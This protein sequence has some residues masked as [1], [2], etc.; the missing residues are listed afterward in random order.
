MNPTNWWRSMNLRQKIFLAIVIAANLALWL[1]T[2]D[3]ERLVARDR[4]ILLGRYS[5]THFTWIMAVALLSVVGL[6]IDQA[7]TLATYKKR[8]F[9]V[10]AVVLFL[11]PGLALLDFAIR[12]TRP[13]AY[14]HD[15]L[16]YHRPPNTT[17]DY[18]FVDR[19]ETGLVLALAPDGHPP[20]DCR[21]TADA[22]GFRN[23]DVQPPFDVIALGDSF[24]EGCNVSDDQA[25]PVR[26]A[27]QAD[28]S[29][30]NLG[31]TG[32]TPRHYLA[33]L[34]QHGDEV[35][36]AAVICLL[37]EG[38]DFE[39]D[40]EDLAPPDLGDR[41]EEYFETSPLRTGME[42]LM[43][44]FFSTAATA[45]DPRH[46]ELFSWLPLQIPDSPAGHPYAFGPKALR[47]HSQSADDFASSGAWRRTAEQIAALQAY[48]Q[49]R[50]IEL[51]LAF[52]PTKAHVVLPLVRDR[53]PMDK[54]RAFAALGAKYLPDAETF[55]RMLFDR[56][57]A[58]EQVLAAWCAERGIE[59]FSLTTTLRDALAAGDYVYYTYDHHWTPAGNAVVA[60]AFAEYWARRAAPSVEP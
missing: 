5:R 60:E 29:L 23:R 48:C 57:E 28:I 17:L 1:T 44:R 52:A 45:P 25:W 27:E 20:V 35:T 14:V 55:E 46:A 26:F 59:F 30:Y 33:A 47:E 12:L 2:S 54:V 9:Q 49:E 34:T 18:T 6:Y 15:V 40:R 21:Y 22:R 38:N 7:R 13:P 11:L 41:F 3:I 43:V 39:I 42:A 51:I 16:A 37:Y 56:L 58:R 36:A 32:Y 4:P 10:L 31:M 19:P 53:L 24:T 8:W 50:R